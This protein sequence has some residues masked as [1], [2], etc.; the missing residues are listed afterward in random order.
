MKVAIMTWFQYHNYGTALQ[1][2]ALCKIIDKLGNDSCVINYEQNGKPVLVLNSNIVP[3]V[4]DK[5]FHILGNHFYCG[6]TKK[7]RDFK[8]K[9]FL[10]KNI[11]FT[12]TCKNLLDLENLNCCFDAFVCGSDQIW[13]P[14]VFNPHYFLDFVIDER[15]LL[16]YAPS[17]GLPKINNPN[18]QNRMREC[19]ERF[20]YLSTREKSGSLLINKLIGRDVESVL[21]PTFLISCDEWLQF[22]SNLGRNYG[23]YLLV[24]MLGRNESHWKSIYKIAKELNL[25]VK[26]IP[27]FT[28]DLKR[29][30]CIKDIVG[31]EEFLSL[32][33]NSS[34]ICTDSFHG[35]SFSIIFNKPFSVFE[36]FKSNDKLNQNSRIYNILQLT[37]LETRL[38]KNRNIDKIREE[39]NYS[40][41]NSILSKEKLASLN[42][43]RNSLN[44]ISKSEAFFSRKN[45]VT[46][47]TSL[48]C[49][50]GA[51]KSVC[52]TDAIELKLNDDGFYQAYFNENTCISCGK[53]RAV[54]PY[55]NYKT[56][57][58]LKECK[59]YSYIDY[60]KEVL[61]T[62]SSGGLAYRIAKQSLENNCA[63]CGCV[64]DEVKHS[65]KHVIISPSEKNKLKYLQG[66]KYLQSKF[67][68]V[69]SQINNNMVVFGTP[70]Q[71]AS[72]RALYGNKYNLLLVDLICHG[73]PSYNL[74]QKY[75]EYLS[76]NKELDVSKKFKT[77]FRYKEKGWRERYIYNENQEKS[78][79]A[80]Q[81]K[82]PFF[83][84]FEH[85]F[86][87]SKSCYEC[88]W[89]DKS[90][91]DIRLGDYWHRK[92][93]KNNTGISMVVAI[94]E[95]GE[96][97]ISRISDEK[98]GSLK[99]EPILD[100]FECQQ[101]KNN[102]RPVFWE[103]LI[104][105]L[106][107][108]K[109]I[110]EILEEYIMPY[111]RLKN[112]RNIYNDIKNVKKK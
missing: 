89:R 34:Y 79:C 37:E 28:R 112:L 109:S 101:I 10:N 7:E 58:E 100:Y 48:C 42:F 91:A 65:A 82:D 62:S 70:C 84:F 16:A 60:D 35:L 23:P 88:P 80:S 4:F 74:Y 30:G 46:K 72:V 41:V 96:S 38:I 93:S 110:S 29:E 71:I 103:E 33:Y 12:K 25:N 104:S 85:G 102:V 36:R 2:T 31:P 73:V 63:V 6:Y 56:N 111:E 94:T 76:S 51:C 92:Y 18:V 44:S 52:P 105:D 40:K 45:N 66:S 5:A 87:Y 95:K 1:V 24:Y 83:L 19:I 57:K 99:S 90:A 20:P 64:Y 59:L 8:F 108:K 81:K 68:D 86:C 75:M 78:F 43:L 26:V 14:S 13:A 49:G 77:V 32:V 98:L 67:Y 107:S 47:D 17:V 11:K 69:I 9:E 27:V 97:C 39:I 61:K 55:L 53:C 21:D 3:F 15:K 22:A 50:C 54:C 106:N